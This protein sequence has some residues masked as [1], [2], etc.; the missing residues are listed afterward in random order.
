LTHACA[1]CRHFHQ[2]PRLTAH[3][4][5]LATRVDSIVRSALERLDDGAGTEAHVMSPVCPEHVI[6]VYR[7]RVPGV[8]MAWATDAA[9]G[10]RGGV[11][12]P[13]DVAARA[14]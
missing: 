13:G 2:E 7:G 14:R 12:G 4:I 10:W 11:G 9:M 1:I 3:F 8:A 5:G 6:D